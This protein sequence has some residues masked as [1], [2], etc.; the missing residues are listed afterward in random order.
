[1]QGN[2]M[3]L[4]ISVSFFV[5]KCSIMKLKYSAKFWTTI[6]PYYICFLIWNRVLCYR[7]NLL[8][9]ISDKHIALLYLFPHLYFLWKLDLTR[10]KLNLYIGTYC[11]P[12]IAQLT[13]LWKTA[14]TRKT[15]IS[16]PNASLFIVYFV[17][18]SKSKLITYANFNFN[19][20]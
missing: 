13:A 4:D 19:T 15:Y 5:T 2:H 3:A 8:V 14:P 20:C 12:N 18:I 17:W 7:T 10:P 11:V 1:M 6:Q 16:N 9:Q